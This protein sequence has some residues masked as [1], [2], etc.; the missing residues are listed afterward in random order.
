MAFAAPAISLASTA[1]GAIGSM[2][3]GQ[4]EAK[5]DE[6]QA[7]R[8]LLAS[9]YGRIKAAQTGDIM[10][11]NMTRALG[12]IA[13]VRASAGADVRSPAT[14]A[15]RANQEAI[16]ESERAARLGNIFADVRLDETAAKQYTDA[17]T[18]A[19]QSGYL[20]SAGKVIGSLGGAFSSLGSPSTSS[21]GLG[22]MFSFFG[23]AN[24]P[25]PAPAAANPY[26]TSMYSNPVEPLTGRVAGPV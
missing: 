14:A 7:Q 25:A 10:T 5:G 22:S 11:Q 3:Q 8:A 1:M 17:A 4:G 13:A 12:H 18:R 26:P 16:G 24:A 2:Q 19:L 21:G 20:G 9:Q 6:Y 15:I 23:G